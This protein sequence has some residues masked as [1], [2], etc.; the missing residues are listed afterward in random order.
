MDSNPASEP[1]LELLD[2]PEIELETDA[3]AAVARSRLLTMPAAVVPIF[4]FLHIP[5]TAGTTLRYVFK[6]MFGAYYHVHAE[7]KSLDK[8]YAHDPAFYDDKLMLAGHFARG[9]PIVRAIDGRRPVFVT[10]MRDPVKRV[11]SYYDYLLKK[12]DHPMHA[13]VVGRSLRDA[14]AAECRF[15]NACINQ[16]LR[17]TFGP[18]GDTEAEEALHADNY[19]IGRSDN[20]AVLAEAV[21]AV[22]GITPVPPIPTLNLRRESEW[23]DVVRASEQPDIEEARALIREA[24]ALEYAFFDRFEGDLI[25]NTALKNLARPRL[26]RLKRPQ[27]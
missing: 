15:R 2:E 1:D 24:N 13:D 22:S 6:R 4:V 11:I 27:P 18:N 9:G 19:I 7:R 21:S 17:I 25:V 3:P 5:K 8:A 16:Q 26:R 14:F 23:G 10:V 20:L 12:E